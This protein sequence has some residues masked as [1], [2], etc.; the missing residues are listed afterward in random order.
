MNDPATRSKPPL[1]L[2]GGSPGSGKTTLATLLA[3]RLALPWLRKDAIKETLFD[4]LR[5]VNSPE[6]VIEREPSKRLG[7]AAIRLLYA[8]ASD[9]LA[10]GHGCI[11]ESNFYR[12]VSERDLA[13]LFALS[14]A[15]LIHCEAPRDVLLD[16]YRARH[17]AGERHPAH[18]DGAAVEDL[19]RALDADSF[20]PLQ[21]SFPILR[22]NTL[23]GYTPEIEEIVRFANAHR[24]P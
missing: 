5:E 4:A 23:N 16:R 21:V 2:V 6:A 11:V 9:L 15:R 18:V 22:I 7:W 13:P 14:E 3:A 17:I 19:I 20:E 24:A 10:A 8:Q 12:G 1:V